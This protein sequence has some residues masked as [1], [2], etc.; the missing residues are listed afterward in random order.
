MSTTEL[1]IIAKSEERIR[2]DQQFLFLQKYFV[3]AEDLLLLRRVIPYT[4]LFVTITIINLY[5]WYYSVP[6]LTVLGILGVAI[7]VLRMVPIRAQSAD[8]LWYSHFIDGIV[9]TKLHWND[10]IEGLEAHRQ[11]NSTKFTVHIC[12]LL[13]FGAYLGNVFSGSHLA[14]LLEYTILVGPVL[15]DRKVDMKLKEKIVP[16]WTQANN[17]LKALADKYLDNPTPATN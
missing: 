7:L 3:L 10:V 15:H 9:T 4:I 17:K 6:S 12:S 13:L 2:V 1:E 14:T 5:I 8:S 16:H 11:K